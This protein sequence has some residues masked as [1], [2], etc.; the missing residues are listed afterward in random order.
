V[1]SGDFTDKGCPEGFAKAYEFLSGL[2]QRFALSAERCI[3]VP[4]NHDLAEPLDAYARRKDSNGLRDQLQNNGVNL[5]LHGDT[6]EIRRDLYE[7]WDP[8]RV[9]VVGSGSFGAHAADRAEAVSRLYDVLEI[10]RDFSSIRV[11]TREQRKPDSNWQGWHEW[12]DAKDKTIRVP[13]Y[14]IDLSHLQQ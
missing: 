13:Y 3:L 4:G 12:P 2:T 6:H 10:A 5:V 8:R 9:H 14:D 11:R 1:V 7:Y